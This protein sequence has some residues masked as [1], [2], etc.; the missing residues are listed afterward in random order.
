MTKKKTN[1]N[2]HHN[3]VQVI[4]H[5]DTDMH[6]FEEKIRSKVAFFFPQNG[7]IVCTLECIELHV[8]LSARGS[9]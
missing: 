1:G 4:R 9:A 3:Y 7:I 5:N 2:T 6:K 8:Q